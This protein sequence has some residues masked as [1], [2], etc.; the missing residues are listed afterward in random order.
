MNPVALI[1]GASRGIG[2]GIALELAGISY[3]LAATRPPHGKRRP[4]AWRGQKKPDTKF[5]RKSLRP[6][7]RSPPI[8]G[9]SSISPGKT[10][11]GWIFW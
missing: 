4:V 9:D 10:W 3:D 7:S 1:T 2:R 8:A 6:T 5:A 11:A